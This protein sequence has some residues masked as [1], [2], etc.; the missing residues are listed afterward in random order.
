[1]P[2]LFLERGLRLVELFGGDFRRQ[3]LEL[4]VRKLHNRH[5]KANVIV[6]V[7]RYRQ[8]RGTVRE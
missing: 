2:T 4:A 5:A 8:S 3:V 1:M 6:V 7:D